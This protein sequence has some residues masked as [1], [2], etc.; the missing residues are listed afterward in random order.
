MKDSDYVMKLMTKY[1]ILEPT[2]KRTK[3]KFK[4]SGILKTKEFMYK[5]VV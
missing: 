2:Y 4:R 5:E 3:R 1:G